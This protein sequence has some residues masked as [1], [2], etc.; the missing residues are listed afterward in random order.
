MPRSQVKAGIIL[1]GRRGDSGPHGDVSAN[2]VVDD[3]GDD[4]DATEGQYGMLWF[5]RVGA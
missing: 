2:D 4:D 3:A 1:S 5:W